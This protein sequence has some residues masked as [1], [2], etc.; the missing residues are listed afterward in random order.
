MKY[1]FPKQFKLLNVFTSML[2]GHDPKALC[3][4]YSMRDDEIAQREAQNPSEPGQ[5]PQIP[6]RLQ[7]KPVE[8]IRQLQTRHKHCS[9]VHLLQHYCPPEVCGHLWFHRSDVNFTVLG[10]LEARS[11]RPSE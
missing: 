8:L 7:G 6:K 4:D 1:I 2:S 3:Q 10:S 5:P 11:R 9:Y